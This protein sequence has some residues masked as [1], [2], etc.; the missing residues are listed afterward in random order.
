MEDIN[1]HIK[2]EDVDTGSLTLKQIADAVRNP[3]YLVLIGCNS[4]VIIDFEE[5]TGKFTTIELHDGSMSDD[6]V[7]DYESFVPTIFSR[8]DWKKVKK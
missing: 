1:S 8:T 6:H 3:A 4:A 5:D 2:L 7:R